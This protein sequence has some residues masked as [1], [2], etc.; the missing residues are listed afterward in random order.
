MSYDTLLQ[1]YDWE[2][3]ALAEPCPETDAEEISLFDSLPEE[4]YTEEE[5]SQ[6]QP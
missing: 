4:D 1:P 3:A 2:D 5:I 6:W